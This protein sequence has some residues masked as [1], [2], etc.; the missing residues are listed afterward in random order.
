MVVEGLYIWLEG[1]IKRRQ[2]L[3]EQTVLKMKFPAL[4]DLEP[5]F[6]KRKHTHQSCR[7]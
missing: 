1:N 3:N 2:M 6:G 5:K 4:R 7:H